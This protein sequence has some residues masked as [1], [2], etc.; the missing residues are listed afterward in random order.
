MLQDKGA[1]GALVVF[2]RVSTVHV[3][4]EVMAMGL[5]VHS[6]DATARPTNTEAMDTRSGSPLKR[7][8]NAGAREKSR[9]SVTEFAYCAE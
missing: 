5:L 3:L 8:R 6:C 2:G 4:P 1:D 7:F 9:Q